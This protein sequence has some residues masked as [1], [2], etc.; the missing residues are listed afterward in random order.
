[1][2]VL[3][4]DSSKNDEISIK[5]FPSFN[6]MLHSF[7]ARKKLRKIPEN[8]LSTITIFQSF[9]GL[10]HQRCN[11]WFLGRS[12]K[13]E[14]KYQSYVMFWASKTRRLYLTWAWRARRSWC[15]RLR[16]FN[17]F[18]HWSTSISSMIGGGFKWASPG[19]GIC[20]TCKNCGRPWFNLNMI[21]TIIYDFQ[22]KNLEFSVTDVPV[23]V[24]LAEL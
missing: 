14:N 5:S 23:P 12:L 8:D 20:H 7:D 4:F 1:M 17:Y 10:L 18:C 6:W 15:R 9:Q 2:T 24:C 3:F 11:L 22:R 19:L 21:W 13:E 16:H